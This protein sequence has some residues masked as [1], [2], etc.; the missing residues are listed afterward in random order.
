MAM[1]KT[2]LWPIETCL[3]ND[4]QDMNHISKFGTMM[5]IHFLIRVFLIQSRLS[6]LHTMSPLSFKMTNRKLLGLIKTVN[7]PPNQKV[8]GNH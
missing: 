8:R 5:G 3:S 1:S 6:L 2:M 4:G 7:L